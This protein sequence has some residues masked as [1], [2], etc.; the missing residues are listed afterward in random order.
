M[1]IKDT[2]KSGLDDEPLYQASK[3]VRQDGPGIQHS[4]LDINHLREA[5]GEIRF[6]KV[7]PPH[8]EKPKK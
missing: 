2:F 8:D 5:I 7:L 3:D 1:T 4:K 6:K